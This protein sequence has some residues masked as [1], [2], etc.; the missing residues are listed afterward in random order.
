[1]TIGY[2]TT[3]PWGGPTN[4]EQK[5]IAGEKLHT[6]RQDVKKR[7]R[8]GMSIQHVIGN[9]TKQ[10]RTFASGT[11]EA[12]QDICIRFTHIGEIWEV[13]VDDN[14][15]DDWDVIAANDG[16]TVEHF[17]RWF[18]ASSENGVFRGRIIHFTGKTFYR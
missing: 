10:R 11:C 1:M 17:E 15:I 18:H 8:P 4:F 3:F 7:W 12:V 16:L 5:I 2:S 13:S 9:R 6:I 14:C